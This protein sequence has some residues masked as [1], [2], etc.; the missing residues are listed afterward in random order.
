MPGLNHYREKELLQ[1]VSAGDEHAFTQLFHT[2]HQQLAAHIFRL[3]ESVE[4]AEEIVQ[5]VFLKIWISREALSGVKNF[6]AYLFVVSKN[7]AL[8]CL[9]KLAK[10][11]AL[12]KE[13]E[14]DFATVSSAGVLAGKQDDS[15]YYS[16]IDEA[17]DQLPPQQ[18]KVYLLSR[19]R[20]LRY[21]EIAEHL[22][23]SRETVKKYLQLAVGSVSTYIRDRMIFTGL[24]LGFW[25]GF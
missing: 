4:L 8:N 19:H 3:T 25:K 14:K 17:I 21:T 9:K 5:D 12:K 15:K 16:L 1:Q 13:W 11:R 20:R 22:H 18:K 7:H 6:R 24:F 10:E 23:L 2:Y